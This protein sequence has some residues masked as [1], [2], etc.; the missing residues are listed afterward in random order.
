MTLISLKYMTNHESSSLSNINPPLIL[1]L[2]LS[3]WKTPSSNSTARRRCHWL[4]PTP[5][6]LHEK[7]VCLQA[8]FKVSFL[9]LK[10]GCD[11]WVIGDRLATHQC[12]QVANFCSQIRTPFILFMASCKFFFIFWPFWKGGLKLTL[13][14]WASLWIGK[15]I[16]FWFWFNWWLEIEGLNYA[17]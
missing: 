3:G 15:L 12:Y 5:C 10:R 13:T 4:S 6:A 8:V 9:S 1:S 11:H 17:R 2:K 7:R 14:C 16:L